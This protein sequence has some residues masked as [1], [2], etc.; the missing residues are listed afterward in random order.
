MAKNT[1]NQIAAR[2]ANRDSFD[3]RDMIYAPALVELP[4]HLYPN[5]EWI[6]LLNQG[7]QGA[8]TGFGLAA[9]INYQLASRHRRCSANPT[10]RVSARM[11]FQIA[12]RYDQWA[13]ESYDWSSARGAMKSWY[14]TGVC[15]EALW[16][17][18]PKK[19]IEDRLTKGRQIDALQAPLGAYYR[20]LPRRSDVHAALVEA[21]AVYAVADTH[22]G[23][24]KTTT[25]GEITYKGNAS[26]GGGHAF[27][28]IGYTEDGFLVQN[29]WGDTWGGFKDDKGK[30]HAGVALWR[31]E[32]FDNNVWDLWVARLALPVESLSALA[33]HGYRRS[34][35]GGKQKVSGPPALEIRDHYLHIGD[36]QYDPKGDYPSH[37]EDVAEVVDGLVNGKDGKAPGNIVLYAHGGLNSVD[38]SAIR[39][40][41]WRHV[42]DD[43][44]VAELHFIWEAG[45]LAELRDVLLGKEKF[46]Q[47]RVAGVS[48][49]WD[50]WVEKAS[51]PLGYPLWQEMLSD[52]ADAFAKPAA[53]GS[54]FV[55]KLTG[56]MAKAKKPPKVHLV[57]HSAGSL[58]MG[59]LLDAWKKAAGVPIDNLVFFAPACT[60]DFFAE[61]YIPH[62]GSGL[63][64]SSHLFQLSDET[65]RD[66][67][68]AYIY[69]KSLL[70]LVARSYQPKGAV[71][72]LLGME[73]YFDEV[74]SRLRAAK[75]SGKLAR[76]VAVK[77][78]NTSAS[79]SHGGFDNDE[80]TMNSMLRIVLGA[81]PVSPFKP[82]DLKGY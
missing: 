51:Q 13:G 78:S 76:T 37:A 36:G 15:S 70:Y 21:S 39:C 66:D 71:V 22:A 81:K 65:E 34:D 1:K 31:Y 12:K 33:E 43:N 67:N 29:S 5:W 9:V 6:V 75:L 61:R 56:A 27:A 7:R 38:G 26:S 30:N 32:D 24:D 3:S 45:M 44:G 42:F 41:N 8:C 58:W 35:T 11:L 10:D 20:V 57:C 25:T 2:D 74:D 54:H 4:R 59:H 60:V 77:G 23:W 69:R 64:K 18:L 19:A 82:S 62:L 79:D 17:N 52:A 47:E 14:K 46:V 28:I 53:A 63:V 80:A 48:D 40:G 72:P 73:K 55:A 68:V 49:W 16:P 50:D